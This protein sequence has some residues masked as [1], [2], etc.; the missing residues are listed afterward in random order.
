MRLTFKRNKIEIQN[1][2]SHIH[3]ISVYK[4]Y[5]VIQISI[6]ISLIKYTYFHILNRV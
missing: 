2:T 6:S 4:L 5:S 1:N 3:D